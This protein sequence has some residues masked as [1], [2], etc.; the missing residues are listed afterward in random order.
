M[1]A[2]VV[3]VSIDEPDA[4]LGVLREEVVPRVSQ[5]PGFVTGYWTRRGNTGLS[6]IVFDS[7][8]AANAATERV[9]SGVPEGIAT[10]EKIEVREVVA[11]A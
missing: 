9:R 6:M 1:H 8:D 7:E 5:A 10:V 11:H 2:V 4:D 3:N